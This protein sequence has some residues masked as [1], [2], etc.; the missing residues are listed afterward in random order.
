LTN[1][2][3]T[4]STSII[5][6]AVESDT[7]YV[8]DGVTLTGSAAAAALAASATSD[9]ADAGTSVS[10]GGGSKLSSFAIV[11]IVAGSLVVLVIIY[12]IWY[13]WVSS[14]AS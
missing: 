14:A 13:H 6:S 12:L 3:S 9:N 7:T 8:S 11:G 4:A 2:A 5:A 1:P 10:T